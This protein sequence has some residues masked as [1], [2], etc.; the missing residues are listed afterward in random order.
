MDLSDAAIEV[1]EVENVGESLANAEI[2]AL[3]DALRRIGEVFRESWELNSS[4]VIEASKRTLTSMYEL[5]KSIG[6]AFTEAWTGG[7]GLEFLNA[8]YELLA[9]ILNIIADI[10][11]AWKIA[12]ANVGIEFFE[13]VLFRFTE[14][15]KLINS[16]GE[17]F[18]EAWNDGTGVEI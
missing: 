11:E 2:E 6:T 13:S 12:F 1:P 4:A 15:L 5:L 9:T 3:Q 17:A 10:A 8:V 18:R 16:V 7:A 14:I